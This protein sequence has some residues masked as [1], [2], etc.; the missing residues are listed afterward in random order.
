[1]WEEIERHIQRAGG[2]PFRLGG[3]RS[4]GG[5]SINQAFCIDDKDS[6]QQYFVKLN[7]ASQVD[8]FE[9]EALGLQELAEARSVRIPQ[10][11]CWG[12]AEGSSYIVLEWIESGRGSASGWMNLGRQLALQHRTTSA[13][14]FGWDRN[15]TIGSTPQ[16]NPWTRD[17]AAFFTEHRID[18]QLQLARER[19]THFPQLK[20]LFAAL[21]KLLGH[22][23]AASLVHGDLWSGNVGFSVL[24]EP[25]IFDP[26]VYWGDRE[27]DLAM[28]E[29]FGGFPYGFYEGYRE[30]WPLEPGYAE[31]KVVYNLYHIL[32][33]FNLFGGGYRLQAE[34]MIQQI[35]R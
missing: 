21:P 8:M 18:Y 34:Q 19:G 7:Q 1:M 5:G 28:T 35:I 32:N 27:V 15:N 2:V 17:W 14:G 9:A 24:G 12:A 13:K 3:R 30:V 22:A 10:V 33:H 26:A 20:R 25:I 11:V 31:R 29:L 23:P 6:R 4:V 16:P